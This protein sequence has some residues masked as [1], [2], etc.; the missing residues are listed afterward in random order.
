MGVIA[1]SKNTGHT[2]TK[3][4][5]CFTLETRVISLGNMLKLINI[6]VVVIATCHFLTG[7]TVEHT[8][9]W[10]IVTMWINHPLLSGPRNRDRQG[11]SLVKFTSSWFHGYNGTNGHSVTKEL[12]NKVRADWLSLVSD[13]QLAGVT[14]TNI[15]NVFGYVIYRLGLNIIQQKLRQRKSSETKSHRNINIARVA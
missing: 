11:D 8:K 9:G 6:C 1:I 12:G 10:N 15:I 7:D 4:K 2:N 14:Q 3:Q 5:L 13:W